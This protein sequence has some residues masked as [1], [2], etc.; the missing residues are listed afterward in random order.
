M[1]PAVP[2][3]DIAIIGMAATFA[4]AGDLRT[5]WENVLGKVDAVRD[6]PDSWAAPYFDPKSTGN[7]RIYTRRGGFLGA[8]AEFD[9]K[10][11]G[12]MPNSVDGGEPDQFLA[13]KLARDALRDAGYMDRTFDRAR[14]G[15][16]LGH[17]TYLHRGYATLIQHGLVVDQTLELLRQLMPQLDAAAGRHA[18]RAQGQPSALHRREL[19]RDG[20]EHH[21]RPHRQPARSHGPELHHRCRLRVVID[22]HGSRPS[23]SC[24]A[25]VAT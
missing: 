16:I 10:E 6:A 7:D 13:L 9:P 19:S 3:S 11:F 21:L 12:I 17:S 24:A 20:A 14:T 1:K 2:S 18:Q 8:L 4:G 5:Y 15:V 25:V 23:R 22:R